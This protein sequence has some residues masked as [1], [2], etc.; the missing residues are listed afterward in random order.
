M[1]EII[2]IESKEKALSPLNDDDFFEAHRHPLI[3]FVNGGKEYQ[4]STLHRGHLDTVA[5]WKDE[6]LR[7][8]Y[9]HLKS[10]KSYESFGGRWFISNAQKARFE[11]QV[12]E[13]RVIKEFGIMMGRDKW[14]Q[15]GIDMAEGTIEKGNS[16]VYIATMK[17]LFRETYGDSKEI[18][19]EINMNKKLEVNITERKGTVPLLRNDETFI[20]YEDTTGNK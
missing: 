6:Y 5:G 3:D 13:W 18:K 8:L 1:S 12:P 4:V 14:E 11:K 9:N 2:K 20:D 17:A 19:H 7:Y 16:A 10:G 15:I